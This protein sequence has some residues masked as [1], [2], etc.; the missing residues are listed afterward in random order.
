MRYTNSLT[1]SPT[2]ASIW[3]YNEP[4]P[5]PSLPLPVSELWSCL[6][7]FVRTLRPRQGTEEPRGITLGALAYSVNWRTTGRASDEIL[8]V[9]AVMNIDPTRMMDRDGE[10]RLKE[11]YLSVKSLPRDILLYASPKMTLS[12]FH[13]A[14]KTLMARSLTNIEDA[15]EAHTL[16]CTPDGLNGV[17][18]GLILSQSIKWQSNA[19][20]HTSLVHVGLSTYQ[21]ESQISYHR[22]AAFDAVFLDRMPFSQKDATPRTVGA[23]VR[24]YVDHHA[25]TK[26]EYVG[27]VMVSRLLAESSPDHLSGLPAIEATWEEKEFCVS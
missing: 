11:F 8:A 26:F 16:I 13:W 4:L 15:V 1:P 27:R 21:L 9:A 12:S 19:E 7:A 3:E 14:P 5:R 24:H 17:F 25:R 20:W 18:Q 2:A 6:A 10:D 22:L 23:A